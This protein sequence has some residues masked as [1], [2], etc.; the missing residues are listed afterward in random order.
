MFAIAH[1][2]GAALAAVTF[3]TTAFVTG[4]SG[5]YPASC[6]EF[7]ITH[8]QRDNGAAVEWSLAHECYFGQPT[9][10]VVTTAADGAV[11]D[12]HTLNAST[13]Q[14]RSARYVLLPPKP[15]CGATRVRVEAR[16]GDRAIGDFVSSEGVMY[17]DPDDDC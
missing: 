13:M 6:Q 11:V 7:R 14:G 16:Y 8:I 9:D 10:V 2:V 3:A 4:P 17:Y 15:L 12:R 5:G 1:G